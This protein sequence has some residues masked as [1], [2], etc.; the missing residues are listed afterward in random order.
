[1]IFI[2]WVGLFFAPGKSVFV[3]AGGGRI[4]FVPNR[5]KVVIGV[6]GVLFFRLMCEW[7]L[8]TIFRTGGTILF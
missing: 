7:D 6:G 2:R 3:L 5:K 4:F 8:P 1:L